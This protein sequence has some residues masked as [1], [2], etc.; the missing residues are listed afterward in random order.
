MSSWLQVAHQVD[1]LDG[2]ELDVALVEQLQQRSGLFQGQRPNKIN[3]Y[4]PSFK[5]Y[6]TSEITSC[7]KS[8]WPAVSITGGECKLQCDHCK[9]KVLEPMIPATT[10][11]ALWRVVNEQIENGAQGMLLT[12]GSNHR[13]EVEYDDFYPTLR[14]IKGVFPAFKIAL[15]TALVDQDGARRM[16]DSGI[17]AAMMDVIGSQD[18]ITQVYHLRRSV[19]DFERTLEYLVATNVK[20]VPHIVIGLHYGR[21]LGEWNALEI[22]RRHMPGALVLVVAMP[23]YAPAARPFLTP[24]SAE[25]GRFFMDARAALPGIP[26]LL[27]CARPAGRAKIEIDSYAVM[28]GLNGIAHPVDGAVE[29]AVRL[30]KEVRVTPSCCSIAIGDEVLALET[31]AAGL[32]V[33]IQQIIAQERMRRSSLGRIKVVTI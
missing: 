22:I 26:L 3:F 25:V 8:A 10:P 11:Q 24:D 20:V 4:T 28:A 33:D 16:E 31:E 23:F 32:Q 9:A 12:G 27:G 6:T 15:H 14:R 1:P 5:S 7:G 21:L 29:L 19:D 2:L 17:D 18:T 30:G 13:N